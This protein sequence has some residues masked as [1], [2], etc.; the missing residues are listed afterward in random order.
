MAEGF[1]GMILH[2]LY[3][4]TSK[5]KNRSLDPHQGCPDPLP[6]TGTP[7]TSNSAPE[8]VVGLGTG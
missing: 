5:I 6:K 7:L 3:L 4:Q 1:A 8:D 2:V